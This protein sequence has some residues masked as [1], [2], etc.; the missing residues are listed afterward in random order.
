MTPDKWFYCSKIIGRVI[1]LL[2][3]NGL[4]LTN[5]GQFYREFQHVVVIVMPL[6]M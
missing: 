3:I 1:K 2:A 4:I 6:L 5:C